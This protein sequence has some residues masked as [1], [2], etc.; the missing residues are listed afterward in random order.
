[1]KYYFVLFSVL[2]DVHLWTVTKYIWCVD[3]M[4]L[5]NNTNKYWM[6]DD[7]FG[8]LPPD[9][10]I[11][12]A[13]DTTSRGWRQLGFYLYI[14]IFCWKGCESHGLIFAP[15]RITEWNWRPMALS[16]S[17][18]WIKPC[19]LCCCC[20]CKSWEWESLETCTLYTIKL[21]DNFVL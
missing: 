11:F 20:Y 17:F 21:P 10:Y 9:L 8:K 6:I 7:L 16:G 14:I 18:L 3:H 12:V 13:A 19:M 2:Y 4:Y 5:G 15:H 1:M